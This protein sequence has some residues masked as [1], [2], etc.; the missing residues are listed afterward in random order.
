MYLYAVQRCGVGMI[1]EGTAGVVAEP[2]V[3]T[4]DDDRQLA[5]A[6]YGVPAG[7]P[8]VVLHGTPGCR[9]TSAVLHESAAAAGVRVIAVDRPGYGRSDPHP[10]LS[11]AAYAHDLHQLLDHL[12]LTRVT[13]VGISGGG[14]FALGCAQQIPQRLHRLVLASALAPV[15]W[16]VRRHLPPELR[17]GLLLA[18]RA[19]RVAAAVLRRSVRHS[20]DPT[21]ARIPA[22]DQRALTRPHL[23][24]VVGEATTREATRQGVSA[25]VGDLRLYAAQASRLDAGGVRTVILHGLQ[26]RNVPVPLARYVADQ[27]SGA[28]LQVIDDAGHLLLAERP[29]LLHE[30][31]VR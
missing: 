13:L 28:R 11:F 1:V 9:L 10:E 22:P 6:D 26:D 24:Q 2:E 31:V 8:L 20:P 3:V 7:A 29:E 12:G 18:R 16:P 17:A 4:L 5:F 19:P 21:S 14:G 23:R 25:I 15:P 30:L 27:L